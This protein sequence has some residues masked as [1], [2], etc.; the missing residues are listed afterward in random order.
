M[1]ELFKKQKLAM[2]TPVGVNT[3]W[4]S[5]KLANGESVEGI[6]IRSTLPKTEKEISTRRLVLILNDAK[7]NF[8]PHKGSIKNAPNGLV[9]K[10]GA[11]YVLK[12]Q[13][14]H[15][16]SFSEVSAKKQFKNGT[17]VRLI[18][19]D[20]SLYFHNGV[21][22]LSLNAGL[23]NECSEND[24]KRIM[25]NVNFIKRINFAQEDYDYKKTIGEI[26][27]V[28]NDDSDDE[29]AAV[30]GDAISDHQTVT[31]VSNKVREYDAPPVGVKFKVNNNYQMPEDIY[32][33][34]GG[35]VCV[36]NLSN[37][38]AFEWC[39]GKK[40]GAD[41]PEN[42]RVKQMCIGAA[43]QDGSLLVYPPGPLP[44]VVTQ[45]TLDG[46]DF[47]GE[48]IC[49]FLTLYA[50]DLSGLLFHP[51]NDLNTWKSI[52]PYIQ[53]HLVFNYVGGVDKNKTKLIGELENFDY[54]CAVNGRATINLK[55][56]LLN[57]NCEITPEECMSVLASKKLGFD[58]KHKHILHGS[59]TLNELKYSVIGDKETICLL[60][61]M[62]N[63][64]LKHVFESGKCKFYMIGN[65]DD[66]TFNS[67]CKHKLVYAMTVDDSPIRNL[68]SEAVDDIEEAEF[69]E[70]KPKKKV[71]TNL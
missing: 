12:L 27:N 37:P 68:L 69:E 26:I 48:L 19:L 47:K 65:D 70:E 25:D 41:I 51:V 58:P 52:G 54:T 1:N 15:V 55:D 24:T 18:G 34:K 31:N 7:L 13:K 49:V 46:D 3:S 10:S 17:A 11:S 22:K 64:N 62:K 44:Y 59:Y 14:N 29:D 30:G 42:L 9:P 16:Y 71:K 63:V 32:Q 36:G 66:L 61:N 20:Y 5:A 28:T 57:V 43:S 8:I 21:A 67:A 60:S 40:L 33:I 38:A 4:G 45:L 50:E 35:Q 53:K 39:L 6:L 23:L 2:Q 56:T